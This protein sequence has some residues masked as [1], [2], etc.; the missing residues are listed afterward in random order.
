MLTQR[1]QIH[2]VAN[3]MRGIETDLCVDDFDDPWYNAYVTVAEAT[4]Q[5]DAYQALV[6]LKLT[7]ELSTEQ[8]GEIMEAGSLPMEF[9]SLQEIADD[10]PEVDWLWTN[11]IPRG[12]ISLLGA[13]PG[14]GKSYVALDLARRI[15]SG[16][17]LPERRIARRTRGLPNRLRS[18]RYTTRQ[19]S[20]RARRNSG[21]STM[22][23]RTARAF[24]AVGAAEIASTMR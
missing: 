24:L 3:R 2:A 21:P 6:R 16:C 1:M 22:V 9:P 15:I 10:L 7:G 19:R 13:V 23:M 18:R 12:M 20:T 11:W 8:L 14:A 5:Q 17:I 4:D